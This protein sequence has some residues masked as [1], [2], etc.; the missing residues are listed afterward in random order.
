MA[1]EVAEMYVPQTGCAYLR[2][3]NQDYAYE[4][5]V[6]YIH[7]FYLRTL[8][9]NAGTTLNRIYPEVPP[10]HIIWMPFRASEENTVVLS[11]RYIR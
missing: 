4:T 5:G 7:D 9:I 1:I 3:P 10:D 6:T 8:G 11:E 2:N